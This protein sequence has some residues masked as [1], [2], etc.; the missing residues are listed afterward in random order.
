MWG[1]LLCDA[2][3]LPDDTVSLLRLVAGL[4]LLPHPAVIA[5]P[6][7]G[8]T[9]VVN[10]ENETWGD[11]DCDGDIRAS[12]VLPVLLMLAGFHNPAVIGPCPQI[13]SAVAVGPS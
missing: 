9:V 5:C 12:D 13:G 3:V 1:D 8:D 6:E 10:E 7:P 11:W 4:G 2:T